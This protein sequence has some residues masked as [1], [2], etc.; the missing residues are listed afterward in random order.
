[1]ENNKIKVVV[2]D[3]HEL[4]RQGLGMMLVQ[5]S[6]IDLV[7]SFGTA[8]EVLEEHYKMQPDIFLVDIKMPEINGFNLSSSLKAQNPDYK[9]ILLSMEVNHTY[10][11][12]AFSEKIDGYIPKNS[13]FEIV[14]AAIEAVASGEKYYDDYIKDYIF[15]LMFDNQSVF[16]DLDLARLSDREMSIFRLLADGKQNK[17][18]AELLFISTKTVETHRNNILKKLNIGSTADLV[19]LAIA[20]EVTTNPFL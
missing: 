7:G 6:N 8:V 17:T 2:V 15:R 1:M 12:R 19:K 20:K 16:E 18:I 10:I 5:E 14:M 3:D 11:K 13:N 4:F 9:I